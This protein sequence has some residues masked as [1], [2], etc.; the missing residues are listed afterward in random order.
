VTGLLRN[1]ANAGTLQMRWAN[2]VGTSTHTIKQ[3]SYCHYYTF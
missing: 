2:E 1:G 3:G